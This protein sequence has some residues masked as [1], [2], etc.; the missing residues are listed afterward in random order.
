MEVPGSAGSWKI[1]RFAA[2]S[3]KLEVPGSAGSLKS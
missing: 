1:V 2:V 3:L